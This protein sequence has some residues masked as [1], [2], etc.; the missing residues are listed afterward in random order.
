MLV[1]G[2][3]DPLLP[4]CWSLKKKQE[5]ESPLLLIIVESSPDDGRFQAKAGLVPVWIKIRGGGRN[6]GLII[7]INLGSFDHQ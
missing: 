1:V 5:K 7:S 6:Q 4:Y 2:D 3:D